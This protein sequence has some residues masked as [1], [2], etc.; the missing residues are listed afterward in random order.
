MVCSVQLHGLKHFLRQSL[1]E[2]THHKDAVAAHQTGQYIYPNCIAQMQVLGIQYVAGHQ[3]SPAPGWMTLG[4]VTFLENAS[5][6]GQE[7][8]VNT[9]AGR[10]SQAK[11]ELILGNIMTVLLSMEKKNKKKFP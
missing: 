4:L 9:A 10:G 8:Y 5:V 1:E 6:L 2:G 3:P 11:Q 7:G